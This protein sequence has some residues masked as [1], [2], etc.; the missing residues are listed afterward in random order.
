M[1]GICAN[2]DQVA[3]VKYLFGI[4]EEKSFKSNSANFMAVCKMCRISEFFEKMPIPDEFEEMDFSE[5]DKAC[6]AEFTNLDD[7][8][9]LR[10][11][12]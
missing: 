11:A 10:R 1:I 3:E 7:S 6:L 2:K 9:C 4:L 5:V 8:A 12:L